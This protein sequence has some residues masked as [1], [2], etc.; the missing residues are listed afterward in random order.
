MYTPKPKRDPYKRKS[1]NTIKVNR[2][3][4]RTDTLLNNLITLKLPK[5]IVKE[6]KLRKKQGQP[7]TQISREMGISKLFINRVLEVYL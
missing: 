1:P 6:I 5:N 3:E 4:P 7:R 2:A